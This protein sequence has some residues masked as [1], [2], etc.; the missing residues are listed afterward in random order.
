MS[1]HVRAYACAVV[2]VD[3]SCFVSFLGPLVRNDSNSWQ[4]SFEAIRLH[5][6]MTYLFASVIFEQ[7]RLTLPGAI[8]DQHFWKES[9]LLELRL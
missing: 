3:I 8:E 6:P 4:Q 9:N 5:L 1:F 2:V 7:E